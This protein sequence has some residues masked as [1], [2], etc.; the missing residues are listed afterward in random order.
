M[1]QLTESAQ[2]HLLNR[3][4][5]GSMVGDRE[6][7]FTGTADDWASQL[8]S[9]TSSE[10]RQASLRS[11]R[12]AGGLAKR[13]RLAAWW[14]S[15]L[16]TSNDPLG[17]RLALFW[18]GHFACCWSKV[19]DGL[20]FY[21]QLQTWYTLG[22][23]RFADLLK[24][25]LRDTVLL[26][27][28]DNDQNRRGRPNENLARE[29]FELFSLGVGAY[30]ERDVQ[31]ASRVLTGHG[32]TRN[33]YHFEPLHHDADDKHVFGKVVG[34]LDELV[35]RI[36][37]RPE[38]AEF[39]TWRFWLHYVSPD[40]D[41]E[42][43]KKVA[44]EW[45]RQGMEVRWL[46]QRLCSMP[47]FFDA[48]ARNALVKSPVDLCI[49]AIRERT[50]RAE[51]SQSADSRAPM[52][53]AKVER[54]CARMGQRLLDPP[55]VQGWPYGDEWIHTSAWFARE[56]FLREVAES[57]DVEAQLLQPEYQLR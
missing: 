28:L 9:H 48:A 50:A 29:L 10:Q 15:E 22:S 35:E 23:G 49:A 2:A 17:A 52:P 18:H 16:A 34:D 3:L 26:R 47:E 42:Q 12:L 51:V 6:F 33:G 20:G 14:L 13:S 44:T 45:R 32:V 19:P 39:L 40:V 46:L 11:G 57:R 5:G 27:F 54:Y 55:G 43:A 31:E 36:V 41:A 56:D 8:V 4:L 30:S 38:C 37:A 21:G 24:A 53:W 7:G 25:M 1:T